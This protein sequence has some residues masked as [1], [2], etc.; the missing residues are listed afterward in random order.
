MVCFS[1]SRYIIPAD[2]WEPMCLVLNKYFHGVKCGVAIDG[3]DPQFQFEDPDPFDKKEEQTQTHETKD[4]E[5]WYQGRISLEFFRSLKP[6]AKEAIL[7]TSR[8]W[9]S[10]PVAQMLPRVPQDWKACLTDDQNDLA[11]RIAGILRTR[12]RMQ[13]QEIY[14]QDV[15]NPE[16]TIVYNP[17]SLLQRVKNFFKPVFLAPT[18]AE[19]SCLV[20]ASADELLFQL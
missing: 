11:D 6:P 12:Q 18:Y 9:D 8:F 1:Q 20:L 14:L 4:G 15:W 13:G 7:M 5:K 16:D 17:P 3:E 2:L 19:E 10:L